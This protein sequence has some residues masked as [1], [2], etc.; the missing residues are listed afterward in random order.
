MFGSD[1]RRQTTS[2]W[3][4]PDQAPIDFADM[5]DPQVVAERAR[6]I[7]ELLQDENAAHA[8]LYGHIVESAGL[9]CDGWGTHAGM[10]IISEWNLA[11]DFDRLFEEAIR[12]LCLK[13]AVFELTQDE[14]KAELVISP[15]VDEMAHSVF[16]QHNTLRRLEESSGVR[17][18]HQTDLERFGYEVG[19]Y[20]H[21]CY[22]IAW[23]E[24]PDPRYWIDRDETAR[25]LR[26]LDER[27][28]EVGIRRLAFEHDI[29]FAA[30]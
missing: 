14:A 18:Y 23:G 4:E 13:T 21:Q 25:R 26:Y 2:R 10:V 7:K 27:Y 9:Y 19:G 29:D 11:R 3:L 6:K 17:F 28:R 20:V 16:A 22:V 30:V 5:P 15:P 8:E 24:A 12:A 1:E